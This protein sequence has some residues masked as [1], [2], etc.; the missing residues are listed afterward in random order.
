[1]VALILLLCSSWLP[2]DSTLL[3]YRLPD[4]SVS[5]LSLGFSQYSSFSTPKYGKESYLSLV[6]SYDALVLGER[7][8]LSAHAQVSASWYPL[9]VEGS[10]TS[11]PGGQVRSYWVE[12]GGVLSLNWYPFSF[13]LGFGTEIAADDGNLWQ[14]RIPAQY[15]SPSLGYD[16]RHF[17]GSADIRVGPCL[18][19]FRDAQTVIRALRILDLLK[20]N[21]QIQRPADD[22]DVQALAELLATKP[23]YSFHF[24][25]PEK[26][27]FS[28]LETLL[29][30]RGLIH[31]QIPARTWF[32]LREAAET[33]N[34]IARP[35]GARLSV[36]P[37]WRADWDFASETHVDTTLARRT[38]SKEADITV[39]LTS[40]RPLARRWQAS[41]SL[42]WRVSRD[43]TFIRH[44]LGAQI[45]L[46]YNVF[47][48]LTVTLVYA[49]S[50]LNRSVF[51]IEQQLEERW[52]QW[53]HGPT[54]SANYY[55]E[56]RLSLDASV[57]Y[58]W[59]SFRTKSA[60]GPAT[61]QATF[62]WSLSFS[63][64]LLP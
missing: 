43:S 31:P 15:E 45:S 39:G 28:D 22:D 33:G 61:R 5:A 20:Q 4:V 1:M 53:Q 55:Q 50:Y 35:V 32:L 14:R 3:K 54:L 6:P 29:R 49:G 48:C 36:R 37:G 41:E 46:D 18:G 2:G 30:N 11:L 26:N 59:S 58:D 52:N 60:S 10:D 21:Q 34:S 56:D 47:D 27:W 38:Y 64:R 16:E 25:Q 62:N 57:G 24:H 23:S 63:Y 13:P 44:E 51:D 40:S 19:R 9:L 17:T 8:N 42:A 12:P 7:L